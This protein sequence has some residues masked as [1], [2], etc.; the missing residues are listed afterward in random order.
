MRVVDLSSVPT[1]TS[2]TASELAAKASRTVDA[3]GIKGTVLSK[4]DNDDSYVIDQS[5]SIQLLARRLGPQ[6]ARRFVV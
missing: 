3:T 1:T 6:G 5:T 4:K 2:V